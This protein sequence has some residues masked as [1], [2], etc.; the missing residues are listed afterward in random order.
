MRVRTRRS[1]EGDAP[2]EATSFVIELSR[3]QSE[4]RRLGQQIDQIETEVWRVL[5]NVVRERYA[6]GS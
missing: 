2:D 3:L 5:H 6:D 1:T 4:V